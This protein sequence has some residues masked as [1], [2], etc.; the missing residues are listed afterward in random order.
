MNT[1]DISTGKSLKSYLFGLMKQHNSSGNSWFMTQN[2]HNTTGEKEKRR[3]ETLIP[4]KSLVDTSVNVKDSEPLIFFLLF[5]RR[6][7]SFESRMW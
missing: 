4:F 1:H 6:V 2:S 5:D 3:K 7:W